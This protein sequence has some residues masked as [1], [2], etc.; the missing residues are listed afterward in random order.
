MTR[1]VLLIACVCIL[2]VF[3]G[4]LSAGATR[5]AAVET[6]SPSSMMKDTRSLP[7]ESFDAI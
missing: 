2:G 6:L 7:V 3:A 1:V 4:S 5:E